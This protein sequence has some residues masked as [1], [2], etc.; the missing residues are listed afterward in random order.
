MARYFRTRSL[1]GALR[2][3]VL[4][5]AE[6]GGTITTVIESHVLGLM[7]Y[8]TFGESADGVPRIVCREKG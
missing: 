1:C 4:E 8:M 3:K 2:L 6:P 7:R 5:L